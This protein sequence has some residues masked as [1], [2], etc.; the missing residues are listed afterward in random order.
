MAFAKCPREFHS[1]GRIARA[2]SSPASVT[3]FPWNAFLKCLLAPW[4]IGG[5]V[6]RSRKQPVRYS[7]HNRYI[8]HQACAILMLGDVRGAFGDGLSKLGESVVDAPVRRRG[9]RFAV[10]NGVLVLSTHL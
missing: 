8:P 7:T 6:R 10:R 1:V 9:C 5:H 4:E 3:P 2:G